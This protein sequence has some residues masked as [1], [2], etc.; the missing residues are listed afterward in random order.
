MDIENEVWVMVLRIAMISAM[1]RNQESFA[2]RYWCSSPHWSY[3][4]CWTWLDWVWI[5]QSWKWWLGS[6]TSTVRSKRACHSPV[7]LGWAWSSAFSSDYQ[8]AHYRAKHD[9]DLK[10]RLIFRT[11][12][13]IKTKNYKSSS[14]GTDNDGSWGLK[15][16]TMIENNGKRR[17][18]ISR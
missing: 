10:L 2:Y 17:P 18:K 9:V 12:F 14:T 6:D 4:H 16:A 1:C 13:L 7:I 11:L 15:G 3:S 5:R 8:E